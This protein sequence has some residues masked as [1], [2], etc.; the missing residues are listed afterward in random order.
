MGKAINNGLRLA[1]LATTGAL[2]L[3]ACGGGG[4]SSSSASGSGSAAA[5][6]SGTGTAGGTINVLT[7]DE[8]ISHLDPQRVYTGVEIAFLT[9]YLTRTLVQYKFAPGAAGLELQPD[10]ATD[11]GTSSNGAKTWAFTLKDGVTFQDGTPVTCADV[12]YGVSRTFA[13]DIITDGPTYAISLLDIPKAA[14]GTST[15]KGPFST[16][17]A[18]DTASFDKAV[19]CSADGKTITFNLVRAAGDFPYTMT[20]PA[21]S[22]VPKAKDTGEKYDD[23]FVATG[24]YKIQE[25]TKGQK[26]VLVRNENWKKDSDSYHPAYPDKVVLSFAID[27]AAIDQRL[28]ADAGDDQT[29]AQMRGLQPENLATVFSGGDPRFKD[30]SVDALDPYARYMVINTK[31]VPNL[32]QRE[33]IAVAVNRAEILAARGGDFAG[34]L[35]DGVVKPNLALDYAPSGMWETM[36]GQKVPDTG[37][38]ELAKKLIAESGE[39]MKELTYQYMNTPVDE[40]MAVSYQSAL[41]KA[42]ITVK[43]EPI[44]AG[45]YYAIVQDPKKAKELIRSG[46][47]PDWPNASSVLPELFSTKGGFNMGLV[48]DPT[49][50]KKTADALGMTDRTAQGKVWQ[51]LNK[52]AMSQAW[53]VPTVF[54]KTQYLWGSKVGNG[55]MWDPYGSMAF[56]DLYVKS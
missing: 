19:T 3:A 52:Y 2:V 47:A 1:A 32:K 18:N 8:Q 40:K 46:W 34:I 28:I 41:A 25:Y 22:P 39:P 9:G 53:V 6:G 55:Y 17:A 24:P 56:G 49:F 27:A 38:P 7:L 14:D 36:F 10:M 4:S 43:L 15:Y 54:G 13:T 30:R 12:K 37:D 23:G 45:Q 48:N 44:E 29:A 35:A 31:L 50:E 42:G 33:A 16:D 5:G 21:F 11:L 26:M 51:E 20:L